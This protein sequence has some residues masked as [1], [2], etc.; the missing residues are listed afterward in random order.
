MGGIFGILLAFVAAFTQL[1]IKHPRASLW[2]ISAVSLLFASY[3]VWAKERHALLAEQA[4]HAKPRIVGGISEVINESAIPNPPVYGFDHYFTLELWLCNKGVATNF[5]SFELTLFANNSR[6]GPEHKGE[7][8]SLSGY[9]LEKQEPQK[10]G[11]STE[12]ASIVLELEDYDAIGLLQELETRRGWLRFVVRNIEWTTEGVPQF[13][14]M[15]LVITDG[16]G[17][18]WLLPSTPPWKEP[19]ENLRIRKGKP[20]RYA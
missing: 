1:V 13:T 20:I 17:G 19:D 15:E 9:Y 7:K 11:G 12:M 18:R 4:K 6:N 14:K 2:I 8:V 16:S 5:R 10:R 3:R